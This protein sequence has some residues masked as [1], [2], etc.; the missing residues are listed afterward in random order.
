MTT[1]RSLEFPKTDATLHTLP[2]GLEII[3]REDHQAPLVSVQAWVKTGSIFEGNLLG[4]GVSHLVEHMV[5]KGDGVRGPS[6]LAQAVQSTGGYLNAY[7]SFDRTVYWV[8]TLATGFSTALDVVSALVADAT[9]PEGEY[10][11]EKDV[12]RREMDM[13]K[14]DPNRT[15]NELLFRTVYRQHP[16]REPVI[17]HLELFN[18]IDRATALHYYKERYSPRN[19]FLVIAGAISKEQA[20]AE[21]MARLGSK[22]N[23]LGQTPIIAT[24]PTQTG[25]R[26]AHEEFTTEITKWEM[27]WRIPSMLHPD[28]PALE[29]LGVLMG[30]GPSCILHKNIREK[31]RLAHGISAGAYTPQ[32]DGIFYV[33]AEMDPDKRGAVQEAVEEE[34]A[35]IQDHGVSEADL[36]KAR[37]MFLSEQLGSLTTTRGQASD[38]GSNWISASNLDFTRDYLVKLDTVTPADIQRV[39][40]QYLVE[41]T[42]SIVSLNPRGSLTAKTVHISRSQENT[43]QRVELPNGVTLLLKEDRRLPFVHVDSY[44]RGGLLAETTANNGVGTLTA[45][46]RKKG[47]G[48]RDKEEIAECLDGIGAYINPSS[49]GSTFGLGGSCLTPDRDLCLEIWADILLRPHLTDDEIEAQK[50]RIIAGLKKNEDSMGYV[51]TR[52]LRRLLYGE[53]P[54]SRVAAGTPE[55]IQNLTRQNLLDFNTHHL[56]SGNL[57]VA[58]YGDISTDETKERLTEL[59][60]DL[61][62]G[63]RRDTLIDTVLPDASG[64][65]STLERN[66]RQAVLQVA[67]PTVDLCHPDRVALDLLDEACSDMASRFFIRIRE[68]NGLAYSVGTTQIQGMARGA[69]IF[70]LSTAPDKL[71]FAQSELLQEINNLARNGLTSDEIARAKKTWLGKTAMR[72]QSN[73]SLASNHAVDEIFGLGH[74]FQ[75]RLLQTVEALTQSQ[76]AAAAEK[77]FG[78]K[79][80]TIVRVKGNA[81]SPEIAGEDEE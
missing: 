43:V 46:I 15:L 4:S 59:L 20:L 22:P 7:T 50:A 81:D 29:V 17:G 64:Q 39:A 30:S 13:G 14:D 57:V 61:P 19:M 45:G 16:Y 47:A 63:P 65:T 33:G 44:L 76:L 1:P 68:E 6:E 70:H 37:R 54:F 25:Q 80:P 75:D 21:V 53:H 79:P 78:Q 72:A 24:E 34:I 74:D 66:K 48:N 60:A 11:K 2:N 23:L 52:E 40:Q 31:K 42:S 28:T 49:G 69:F 51:A 3:L 77:Y 56:T 62:K 38:L 8:D 9:F 71:E 12:I 73:A 32:Y 67:F 26:I 10:E 18:A 35:R 58:C 55:T 36:R 27:A 41:P 5:F